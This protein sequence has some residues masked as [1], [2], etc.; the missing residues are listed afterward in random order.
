MP[1]EH[2]WSSERPPTTRSSW[3]CHSIK[4]SIANHCCSSWNLSPSL[5][6]TKL[7]SFLIVIIIKIEPIVFIYCFLVK[8]YNVF[9]TTEFLPHVSMMEVEFSQDPSND[10]T[11]EFG[12]VET[13]L[14]LYNN[15]LLGICFPLFHYWTISSSNIYC[16][17]L[18][19]FVLT[20]CC[21]KYFGVFL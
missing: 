8:S 12:D 1:I 14:N 11:Q 19:P 5:F 13:L 18:F 16:S 15:S 3:A 9:V 10:G 21:R 2:P 7:N 17:G 6:H 4:W 20:N